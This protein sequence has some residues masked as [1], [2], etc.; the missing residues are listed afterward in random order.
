MTSA[1]I[2]RVGQD[3]IELELI[4]NGSD[5]AEVTLQK[6]LLDGSKNYHFV[7]SELSVPLDDCGMHP[8]ISEFPLFSVIRRNELNSLTV[9]PPSYTAALTALNVFNAGLIA[10]Y[11]QA[12]L[13]QI[14]NVDLTLGLGAFVEQE[15]IDAIVEDL[16]ATLAAEKSDTTFLLIDDERDGTYF[17]D[18]K[19][20]LFSPAEFL[21][22]LQ[23]WAQVFNVEQTIVG[24]EDD[25]YGG[26]ESD[27]IPAVDDEDEQD[28]LRDGESRVYHEGDE[29]HELHRFIRFSLS[30]D[31]RLEIKLTK[32]FV[33]S[34]VIRMTNYG[35]ALLGID[36]KTLVHASTHVVNG[37]NIPT[38]YLAFTGNTAVDADGIPVPF[39]DALENIVAGQNTTDIQVTMKNTFF[40]VCDQ[41][42]KISVASHL[43]IA[44]NI[45]IDDGKETVDRDICEA[46]FENALQVMVKY[47]DD[48][49]YESLKIRSEVYSGQYNFIKKSDRHTQFMKLLSS[50]MLQYYRFYVKI[51]Y[52]EFTEETDTWKLSAKKL[53][54]PKNSYW[55]MVVKFISDI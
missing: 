49:E 44:N 43:Q 2:N 50:Y 41:R 46:F 37:I 14:A 12:Q 38:K 3:V 1:A 19:R 9:I 22:S 5:Q 21:F 55:L 20:K 39:V 32:Q 29:Q 17:L 51:T 26:S 48:G 47:D 7:V 4:T 53:P 24:V 28:E 18:P 25:F 52:R 45:R 27:D 6:S 40:S 31:G 33:N 13:V 16:E 34:F 42:L 30:A 23:N 10:G 35:A 36:P 15:Y 11:T 8:L 54:I